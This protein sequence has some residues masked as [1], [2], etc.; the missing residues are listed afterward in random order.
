MDR[1]PEE[2]LVKQIDGS[3]R[4]YVEG[5]SL[6]YVSSTPRDANQNFSQLE[7]F[8]GDIVASLD[9]ISALVLEVKIN[10][11][12]R[13]PSYNTEQQSGLI[14][15]Q[16]RGLPIFYSYN[17][18]ELTQFPSGPTEQLCVLSAIRPKEQTSQQAI[19]IGSAKNLKSAVDELLDTTSG[20]S[21][22]SLA[23][24]YFVAPCAPEIISGIESLTTQ[25][26]LLI[27]DKNAGSLLSLERGN[28]QALLEAIK[29]Q[30]FHASSK[31][32]EQL[33]VTIEEFLAFAQ[34]LA[35]IERYI[36]ANNL[37]NDSR[38]KITPNRQCTGKILHQSQYHI[39]QELGRGAF[40]IHN[41]NSLNEECLTI[42]EMAEIKYKN[43]K[44]T[45]MPTQEQRNEIS[46][47]Y[48]GL[49]F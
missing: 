44:G 40:V 10:Q 28:L 46:S 26:L 49:G 34:S 14:E 30:P 38:Q 5:Q 13:L 11:Q 22:A 4:R 12:G 24:A 9:N 25:S 47:S 35:E 17:I 20:N 31:Y 18:E 7:K 29:K 15:L 1:K 27:Y 6:K 39:L 8:C 43:K 33:S 2:Q 23:L 21:D 3:L 16:E 45:I 36:A 19:T 41:K 37:S 32:S 42:G 48:D